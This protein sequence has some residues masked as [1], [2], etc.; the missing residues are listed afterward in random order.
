LVNT[1]TELMPGKRFNHLSSRQVRLKI[2]IRLI[3]LGEIPTL[4]SPFYARVL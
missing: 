1:P 3:R 4:P 2:R